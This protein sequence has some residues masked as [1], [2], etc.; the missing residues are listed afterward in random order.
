MLAG[1]A[2]APALDE[3]ARPAAWATANTQIPGLPN[4]YRV[5]EN[6]YR[7]AQPLPNG[8]EFL[9]TQ[10]PIEPTARPIKTIISLRAFHDDT[11]LLPLNS[12]LRLEQIHFKTWH[13][14]DQDVVAFLRMV[15]TPALQPVLVHCQHGADRTGTMIAI[16]RIAVQNW[17]K[18]QA[19][20]EMVQ[21][22]Y[23][24]HPIWQNLQNYINSLD[25]DAI[26]QQVA[27]QGAWP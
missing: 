20:D 7:S 21:G 3:S 16:Y 8:F 13:P 27:S 12:K 2:E 11:K 26:K 5:S 23:G 10:Q 17:S 14:E 18:Q 24:Y 19:I 6:L 22:G 4:L 25:I 9:N 1:C 15:N